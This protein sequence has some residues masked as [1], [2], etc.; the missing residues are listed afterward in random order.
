MKGIIPD[1]KGVE[2]LR[3]FYAE[4]WCPEEIGIALSEKGSLSRG[5]IPKYIENFNKNVR[6]VV[7]DSMYVLLLLDGIKYRQGLDWIE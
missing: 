1:M 4:E 5:I 2:E 7:P 3:K 6:K